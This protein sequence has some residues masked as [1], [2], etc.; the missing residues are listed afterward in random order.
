MF[1]SRCGASMAENTHFCPNCGL[2]ATAQISSVSPGAAAAQQAGVAP[3]QPAYVPAV[4]GM[5]QAQP[6]TTA[7]VSLVL[8]ILSL[9]AVSI[10][11]G[12]PAIIVGRQAR[13]NIRA[14]N[15]ALTGES[16][17]QAGIVMGW[18]SVAIA[19]VG[20]VVAIGLLIFGFFMAATHR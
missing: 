6:E 9:V 16:Y 14:S 18:V 1:C 11:A 4:A 7:V 2:Q 15:G 12:I 8:G 3:A 19:V 17:A 10:L 20:A 13:E 5:R